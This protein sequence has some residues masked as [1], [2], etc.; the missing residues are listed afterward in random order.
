MSKK[1]ALLLWFCLRLTPISAAQLVVS[2]EVSPINV[3]LKLYHGNAGS[4]DSRSL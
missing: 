2:G 4:L 3:I 1:A